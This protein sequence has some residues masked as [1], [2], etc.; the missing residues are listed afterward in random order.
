MNELSQFFSTIAPYAITGAI[1]STIVQVTKNFFSKSHYKLLLAIGVSIIGG[2]ILQFVY[3]LPTNW[4]TTVAEVFGA[5]NTV[6]LV[7]IQWFEKGSAN[8]NPIAPV[9]NLPASP[10]EVNNAPA[11]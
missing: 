6:Y 9:S 3:L 8:V 11:N 5:A 10:T 4:L 1:V 7:I 2:I